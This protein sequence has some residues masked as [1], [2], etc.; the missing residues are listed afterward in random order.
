MQRLLSLYAKSAFYRMQK[1]LSVEF[2]ITQHCSCSLREQTTSG[3]TNPGLA[4]ELRTLRGHRNQ[5]E[6]Q[7]TGLQDSRKHLMQQLEVLM[8]R[9][10]VTTQFEC[11]LSK[12]ETCR[13]SKPQDLHF[14]DLEVQSYWSSYP[15]WSPMDAYKL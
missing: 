8:N 11:F 12:M 9:L 15:F 1:F 4:S 10:K 7:L 3:C 2:Q 6:G 14:E 13:L 5:L